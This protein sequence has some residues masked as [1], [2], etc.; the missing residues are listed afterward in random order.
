M[1]IVHQYLHFWCRCFLREKRKFL[2]AQSN[3]IQIVLKKSGAESK[4][5]E[6]V[7]KTFQR[8][9]SGASPLNAVQCHTVCVCVW[10]YYF[11][12]RDTVTIF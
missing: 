8:S 4:G 6:G 1:Y 3:Q 10:G 7:L 12:T 9:R 5:N 2:F 11:S